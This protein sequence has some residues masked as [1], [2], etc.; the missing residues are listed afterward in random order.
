MDSLRAAGKVFSL[1]SLVPSTMSSFS[2]DGG[3]K[4]DVLCQS[5]KHNLLV[6]TH[7]IAENALHQAWRYYVNSR[8]ALFHFLG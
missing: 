3:L 5:S 1:A 2:T 6:G 7:F 8:K 4:G